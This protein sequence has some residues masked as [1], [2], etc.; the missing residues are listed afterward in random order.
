MRNKYTGSVSIDFAAAI[1]ILL[2]AF[3]IFLA[4]CGNSIPSRIDVVNSGTSKIELTVSLEVINQLKALCTEQN[5]P[6][7]FPTRQDKDKA[8]ADCVFEHLNMT[9]GG[10][11]FAD[12][13][14][15]GA[16]LSGFTPEQVATIETTCASL[17]F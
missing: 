4:G 13:Y 12:Q 3:L 14:C 9:T 17:G 11:S 15:N 8:I 16:D 6:I 2:I 7:V 5:A 10:V 1:F